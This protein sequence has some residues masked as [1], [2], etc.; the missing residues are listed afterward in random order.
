MANVRNIVRQDSA[1]DPELKF[2][3]EEMR[4][5]HGMIDIPF[6]D[7]CSHSRPGITIDLNLA[8]GEGGLNTILN[9]IY[10]ALILQEEH[11][12][13]EM[14]KQKKKRGSIIKKDITDLCEYE[15]ENTEYIDVTNLTEE[16]TYHHGHIHWTKLAQCLP[17]SKSDK[18]QVRARNKMWALMDIDGNGHVSYKEAERSL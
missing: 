12:H 13:A 1:Y 15:K 4:G 10:S 2:T 18:V 14:E 6:D 7:V 17:T 3:R 8:N 9:L 11:A 5:F 16:D